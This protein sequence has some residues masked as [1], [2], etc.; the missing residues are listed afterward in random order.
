MTE[1][2]VKLPF[3]RSNTQR[4][5]CQSISLSGREALTAIADNNE[6]TA[7]QRVQSELFDGVFSEESLLSRSETDMDCML[8]KS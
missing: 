4:N 8:R 3:F 2:E 6:L 7:T 1:R 5:K